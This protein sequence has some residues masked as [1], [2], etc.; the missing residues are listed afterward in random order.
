MVGGFGRCLITQTWQFSQSCWPASFVQLPFPD[1]SG[2]VIVYSDADN[3]ERTLSDDFYV[4]AEG[5]DGTLIEWSAS[6]SAPAL[7]DRS[8]AI[9]IEVTAGYGDDANAVPPSIRLALKMLVAHW[10]E[11]REATQIESFVDLPFGVRA[12]L[13]PHRRVGI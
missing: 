12:L 6:F 9:R 3:V 11:R 13:A 4:C 2:A 8:D 10:Y 7:F 5:V 1:C